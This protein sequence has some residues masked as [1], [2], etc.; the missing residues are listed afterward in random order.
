MLKCKPDPY[1]NSTFSE[2]KSDPY[3]RQLTGATSARTAPGRTEL[4]SV[5]F[6]DY[7]TTVSAYGP[8]HGRC[9]MRG[10]VFRRTIMSVTTIMSLALFALAG[11]GG[12]GDGGGGTTQIT[13][14]GITTQAAITSA[15]GE[16]VLSSAYSLGEI[17]LLGAA[18]S[19]QIDSFGIP[20]TRI[21]LSMKQRISEAIQN[22]DDSRWISA[23]QRTETRSFNGDCG[24]VMTGTLTYDDQTGSFSGSISFANYCESGLTCSGSANVSGIV[25]VNTGDIQTFS[26]SSSLLEFRQST[27]TLQLQARLSFYYDLRSSPWLAQCSM[28]IRDVN[29]AK[30]FWIDNYTV[31]VTEGASYFDITISGRIYHHDYGYVDVTTQNRFRIY[32]GN[33]WPSEGTMLAT[34]SRGSQGKLTSLSSSQYRIEVDEEGDGTFEFDR[35]YDW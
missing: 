22:P 2:I 17:A 11:C 27:K 4:A 1:S 33:Q 25:N 34:G 14:T 23:A 35:V 32:N 24:G 6:F 8:F 31:R 28:W 15:N 26:L 3:S 7:M 16:A 10:D 19:Q 12:G 20:Y 5:C 13:Y 18:Q 30:T 21:L 29:T 9:I